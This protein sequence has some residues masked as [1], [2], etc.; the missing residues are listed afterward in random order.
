MSW[1]DEMIEREAVPKA[2][3]E[4]TLT[5]FC[6][7][8]NLATSSYYNELYKKE[9]WSKVEELCFK[10]AKKHTADKLS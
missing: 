3:R 1:I 5:D 6:K 8:H 2:L 10:Q 9:N 7:R 4:E